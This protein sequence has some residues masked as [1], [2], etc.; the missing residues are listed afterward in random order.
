MNRFDQ[1]A[2]SKWRKSGTSWRRTFPGAFAEMVGAGPAP[3]NVTKHFYSLS[4]NPDQSQRRLTR[5]D[6]WNCWIARN[7]A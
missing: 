3:P 2:P 1:R 6:I 4:L 5:E 7:A